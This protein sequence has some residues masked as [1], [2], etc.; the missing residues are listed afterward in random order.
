MSNT[1]SHKGYTGSIDISVADGCLYGRILFI[2]DMIT[3]EGETV[4]EV[5]SSFISAVERYLDYCEETGKPANKPYSGTFNIRVGQ[6][7]HKKAVQIAYLEN[8]TLNDFVSQSI[9]AAIEQNGIVKVEH[10]HQHHVTITDNRIP[11]IMVATMEKP[12]AWE[13]MDAFN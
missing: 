6:E 5:K 1:L 4:A 13:R 3:Y 2:D 10:T 12:Q 9:K 11:A 7:L 8:I